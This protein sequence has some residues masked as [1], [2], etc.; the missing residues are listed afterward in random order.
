[1][2]HTTEANRADAWQAKPYSELDQAEW[3]A[4]AANWV[5]GAE[6]AWNELFKG[7]DLYRVCLPTYRFSPEHHAIPWATGA[8]TVSASLHS[9]DSVV[10]PAIQAPIQESAHLPIDA[11]L[12]S[13][14][15]SPVRPVI[16]TPSH[17]APKANMDQVVE[18]CRAVFGRALNCAPETVDLTCGLDQLGFDSVMVLVVTE[19]LERD[20]GPISQT[21]LFEC[22]TLQEVIDHVVHKMPQAES[23]NPQA[24]PLPE[25]GAQAGLRDDIAIIG[26]AGR[27]PFAE[28]PQ[29]LWENLAA[30]RNCVSEIPANRWSWSEYFE[31]DRIKAAEQGKSYGK[32]G[33]FIS[34]H[35]CFDAL[36]FNISPREARA[37]DPQ[38]RL[39]LETAWSAIEDAGYTRASLSY[40]QRLGYEPKVGV[41][42]GSSWNEYPLCGGH[43]INDPAPPVATN[44]CNIANRVSYW[45]NFKGSSL[46]L[47]TACSS[48]LTALHL[49]CATLR[50]GEND[51]ALVGGVNL[52]LHPNKY[53][54][55]SQG[56]FLSTKG[57]CESF[58]EGANGYVPSE[59]VA[60][61]LLKPKSRAIADGDHIY[62]VIRASALLHGG[63]TNGYSVPDPVQQAAVI[64]EALT[65]AGVTPSDISY[66]E[67]HGT[68]T[69]LGDPIEIAGLT[70]V[71]GAALKASET[72]PGSDKC[73]IGSIKSNLGHCEAAS[74]IIGLTKI[75]LQFKHKQIAASLHSS[76]L[77][78]R[79]DFENS[80]FYVPQQLMSW[81]LGSQS[82]R[83][84]GLSSFGAG[85]ANVHAV[86]EEYVKPIEVPVQAVSAQLVILSAWN[87]SR[88]KVQVINLLSR[89]ESD[90]SLSLR[91]LAYT[92]QLGREAMP[93]R[94]GVVVHS[95]AQLQTLLREFLRDDLQ[96]VWTGR[97]GGSGQ[98]FKDDLV[99]LYQQHAFEQIL[100]RW[101][102]GDSLDWSLLWKETTGQRVSL[103]TYPFAGDRHWVAAPQQN[104]PVVTFPKAASAT[105]TVAGEASEAEQAPAYLQL[106][107][108]EEVWLDAAVPE[109]DEAL[110]GRLRRVVC[111]LSETENQKAM[112]SVINSQHSSIE[113]IF[114]ARAALQGQ[115]LGALVAQAGP[116]DA[117]LYLWPLEQPTDAPDTRQVHS[118]LKGLGLKGAPRRVLLAGCLS[119]EMARVHLNAWIGFERSLKML[120]PECG[121]TTVMGDVSFSKQQPWQALWHELVASVSGAV[122]REEG[123]RLTLQMR[124]TELPQALSMTEGVIK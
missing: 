74:G 99:A 26:L 77:N 98:V 11:V 116:V 38:E 80:R 85:G 102:T 45:F 13:A 89:L 56:Q 42:V 6:I 83:I 54:A 10:Y 84:A 1:V 70:Q 62:G 2:C 39:F 57:L 75:L 66:I 118:L 115:D 36:F 76:Q 35:D 19:G 73:A 67:A 96:N 72:Q 88:L 34:N 24:L 44:S 111:L 22:R 21:L 60:A 100:S 107:A 112:A 113:L 79:I 124:E 32:W 65:Q 31:A 47:D 37:M 27:F 106:L 18:V 52:S 61:V 71:F 68:G 97:A 7:L 123:R 121:M 48:S 92:L 40:D 30:G 51:L 28:H 14:S 59:A 101:V 17:W 87:L 94:L 4:L 110:V 15:E 58:G 95:V 5:H 109:L 20:F 91:D 33:G 78:R 108:F 122:R 104:A 105:V 16:Q 90:A 117:L 81:P 55:L 93:Q 41:Y 103:P 25:Q 63:K 46:T 50:S 49:A 53:R 43:D 9:T 69:A 64:R 119:N 86:L 12:A 82:R 3:V 29:A 23:L 8:S 114:I 120:W